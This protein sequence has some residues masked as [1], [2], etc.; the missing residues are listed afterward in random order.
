MLK[1]FCVLGVTEGKVAAEYFAPFFQRWRF[2]RTEHKT[3][4]KDAF[5]RFLK[6]AFSKST[7]SESSFETHANSTP[8]AAQTP[9]AGCCYFF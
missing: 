7:Y 1:G 4:L 6:E 3:R 9:A 8:Q 2:R 5:F